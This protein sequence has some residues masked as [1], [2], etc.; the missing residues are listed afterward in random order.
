[1]QIMT[2]M[3]DETLWKWWII[4]SFKHDNDDKFEINKKD[5]N[6]WKIKTHKQMKKIYNW[7]KWTW[8]HLFNNEHEEHNDNEDC[9]GKD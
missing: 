9:W 6:V 5:Q 3:K 7:R 2:M 1:M 8:S 4:W